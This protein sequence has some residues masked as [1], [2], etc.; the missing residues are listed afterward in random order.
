[1]STKK[2]IDKIRQQIAKDELS[3]AIMQLK[4]I[5]ENSPKLNE[6]LLQSARYNDILKQIRLGLVESEEGNVTKN[7]IRLGLLQLV[8]EIEQQGMNPVIKDELEQSISIV[9]S[10]NVVIGSTISAGRDIQIGDTTIQT[11]SRTS[12][13][14]RLF[15]FLFVPVLAIGGA[16]L[17]YQNE[18]MKQP[19]NLKV[20]IE[21]QTPNPELPV[22]VGSLNLIYGGEINTQTSIST[23]AIFENIPPGLKKEPFRLQYEADGFVKIDTIFDYVESINIPVKR[24]DDLAL[25]QGYVYEE[26]TDPLEGVEGVSASIG[27][28]SVLTDASGKFNIKIPFDQQR[29]KHRLELFK[30]GFHQKSTWEPVIKGNVI[31]TYITKK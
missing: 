7:K 19:L 30:E 3:D 16:Y 10:K 25:L 31:H 22:Q 28:C 8:S 17:W 20:L 21:N 2:F 24:N 26:G 4:G 27:C 5:L 23:N 18:V 9:K 13:R 6:V 15:L 14:L 12:K 11:E 29:E 1:M